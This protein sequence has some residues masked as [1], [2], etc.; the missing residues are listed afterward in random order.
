MILNS[1]S[2]SVVELP[3]HVAHAPIVCRYLELASADQ[4]STA[5]SARVVV[6]A[7]DPDDPTRQPGRVGCRH[8]L[9]RL[10]AGM[11]AHGQSPFKLVYS[12]SGAPGLAAKGASNKLNISMAHS[13][14]WMAVGIGQGLRIGVDVESVAPRSN[15]KGISE[16]LGWNVRVDTIRDFYAYWTLWEA[17][18]KCIEGSVFMSQNQG[19]ELLKLAKFQGRVA[20]SGHWS[21]VQDVI[22]GMVHFAVVLRGENSTSLVMRNLD[23]QEMMQ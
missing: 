22:D 10:I 13:A 21:G 18:A 9:Q 20:T 8:L 17:S 4:Q 2:Q 19:F 14:G 23:P 11:S 6:A 3:R 12:E 5:S 7:C 16:F 15:M 1:L